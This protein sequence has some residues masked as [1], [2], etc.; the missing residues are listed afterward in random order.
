MR[1]FDHRN[2]AANEECPVCHKNTDGKTVLLPV[3]GTSKGGISEAVQ[4]HLNCLDLWFDKVTGMIFQVVDKCTYIP[5]G[6]K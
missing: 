3:L 2:M 6:G 5:K 4:V 1:T